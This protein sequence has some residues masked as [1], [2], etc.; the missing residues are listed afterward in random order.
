VD[1]GKELRYTCKEA[2]PRPLGMIAL[3]QSEGTIRKYVSACDFGLCLTTGT[4][5]LIDGEF[6]RIEKLNT[7]DGFARIH[8]AKDGLKQRYR[9]FFDRTY[10]VEDFKWQEGDPVK[11]VRGTQEL[12]IRHWHAHLKRTTKGYATV[13]EALRFLDP[14]APNEQREY[15]HDSIDQDSATCKLRWRNLLE[16]RILNLKPNANDRALARLAFTLCALIQDALLSLFPGVAERIAVLS[17]HATSAG[18]QAAAIF[19]LLLIRSLR[20]RLCWMIRLTSAP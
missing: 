14:D 18:D 9:Y 2:D 3:Q 16:F 12:E 15:T 5:T 20:P 11:V 13:A 1:S 19:L 8:H 6:Y 7:K 4:Y 10:R 17:P